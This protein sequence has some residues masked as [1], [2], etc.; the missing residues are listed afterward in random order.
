MEI[1]EK[2]FKLAKQGAM[3]AYK[4]GRGVSEFD[5][6]YQDACM[7]LLHNEKKVAEWREEGRHGENRI[8]HACKMAALTTVAKDRVRTSGVHASDFAYYT[9]QMIRELL[10]DVFD[11]EDWVLDS[12]VER[13]SDYI[14]STSRPSEGN[15]RI[16]MLADV[17]F[18]FESL[19]E[20][21]QHVLMDLFADG[22]VPYGVVA[23]T[24]QVTERTVRRRE[25]RALERMVE[26]L[27]G[28]V[29]FWVKRQRR[30]VSADYV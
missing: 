17:K 29:P 12:R 21:D 25:Q 3:S 14:K 5:D 15:N 16:A 30:D 26:L 27:G 4:S 20:T 8:R 28:E 18:A 11:Y 2:E 22:G 7:W 13:T 23:A 24:L 10:P 19:R 1:S 6:L 9:T